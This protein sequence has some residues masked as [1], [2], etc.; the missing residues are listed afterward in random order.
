M[1]TRSESRGS[2]GHRSGQVVRATGL[3][4]LIGAVL[5]GFTLRFTPE[6]PIA[7][8]LLPLP[9]A[10]AGGFIYFR[11]RQYGARSSAEYIFN[12]GTRTVL[13]LRAFDSDVSVAGQTFSAL[14]TPAMVAGWATEEEQLADVFRPFGE[15]VAIGKPGERLPLPGAARQY[16]D[17]KEWQHIV[18]GMMH[19][20]QLV[21]VRA[22]DSR[23]LRGEVGQARLMVQPQR[24]LVL[25]L[26]MSTTRY[27][28]FRTEAERALGVRLPAHRKRNWLGARAGYIRFNAVGAAEYVPLSAPMVRGGLYKPLRRV[29]TYSLRPVFEVHRIPWVRPPV[30]VAAVILYVLVGLV[31]GLMAV[32]IVVAVIYAAVHK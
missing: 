24:L 8:A 31:L 11:G 2:D 3:L 27:H 21:V 23:G 10:V 1:Q 15:F 20:A 26:R 9:A 6:V 16:A 12:P 5:L 32:L 18:S 17:M 28:R 19:A 30:S 29:F 22:S 25:V 7:L 14:F 4:L 13:Y